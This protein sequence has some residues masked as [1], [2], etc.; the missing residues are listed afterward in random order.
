MTFTQPPFLSTPFAVP[1]TRPRF[2]S[3]FHTASAAQL[4]W[5]LSLRTS[6]VEQLNLRLGK[7]SNEQVDEYKLVLLVLL[8]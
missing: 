3:E 8:D 2:K 5:P 6:W 7:L 1:G 4:E